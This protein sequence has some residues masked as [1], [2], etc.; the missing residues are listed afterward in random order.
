MGDPRVSIVIPTYQHSDFILRTLSSVFEQS[1][2]DYEIIVVNDG[3]KDDTSALLAPLVDAGRI[4]YIEQ[5]NQGQSYARNA[6]LSRA[7]GEYIAFLDDDDIWPPDKLASQVAFLDANPSAGMVGGTFRVIDE[8][9]AFGRAGPYYPTI[10]FESLFAA[11]PFHS[12]GQTLI[13]SSVLKEV[14]GLN[15]T[16]L[17]GADDWDLWFRIAKQS[18]I[19]MRD[20]IALYYRLHAQNASKQTARLLRSC[21]ETIELHLR[22][23]DKHRRHALRRNSQRTIYNG[24]GSHLVSAARAEVRRGRLIS[25]MRTLRGVSP[26]RRGILF[27]S[28]VRAAFL[29]DVV[30]G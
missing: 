20:E 5:E 24:L 27:D 21:C 11:N 19:V 16:I 29:R 6:G 26:L 3:S 17:G 14:G 1:L 7:R 30:H 28:H 9:G 18:T 2:G 15:S 25:A 8:N 4:T 12:P 13:R 23:L 22:S 10:T